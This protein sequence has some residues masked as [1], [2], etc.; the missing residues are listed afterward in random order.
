MPLSTPTI[1]EL[2]AHV[3]DQIAAGEVIEGPLSVVKELI[4]NSLDAGATHIR[5]DLKGGGYDEITVHDNGCGISADDMPRAL[6]K[7]AT[8]KLTT[9]DLW[10]ITS[11][12][13]RGEALAVIRSI[14][15]LSLESRTKDSP[16]G[17]L[18]A[19][20]VPEIQPIKRT[21][22]TT[23]YVRDLFY[24]TPARLKFAKSDRAERLALKQLL[25]RYGLC[26]PNVGFRATIDDRPFFEQ[27]AFPQYALED[28]LRERLR[29]L[30]PHAS[31]PGL[32][33]SAQDGDYHVRGMIASPLDHHHTRQHQYF[34]IQNRP[35]QDKVLATALALAY[36]DVIP[37]GRFP[38]SVVMLDVPPAKIDVNVHPT[39]QEVR[40]AEPKFLQSWLLKT[41]KSQL[42]GPLGQSFGRLKT[43]DTPQAQSILA[44]TSPS[45]PFHY[46]RPAFKPNQVMEDVVNLSPPYDGKTST[47]KTRDVPSQ[48]S[49]AHHTPPE[50][51]LPIENPPLGRV[52][53]QI[54]ASYIVTESKEG[55]VIID[56]HAAAER[57][58]YEKLKKD[59]T[60]TAP[61]ALLVPEHITLPE[62]SLDALKPAF[63][64]LKT[65]GLHL[66]CQSAKSV[67]AYSVPALLEGTRVTPLIRDLGEALS[68]PAAENSETHMEDHLWNTFCHVLGE[69]ACKNSI[70]ANHKLSTDEMEHLLRAME[71]TSL[72]GQCNHGRPTSV[73]LTPADLARL[74]KRA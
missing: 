63:E 71:K 66:E 74:F 37:H 28:S 6:L 31:S 52:L 22:G 54:H 12:G 21:T 44:N 3:V 20:N 2:P 19:D 72:S 1:I 70:K 64:K 30:L 73:L 61:H 25:V 38:W 23:V 45:K 24:N 15:R 7:H 47:V 69:R 4:E 29:N 59:L 48:S 18:L 27:D 60:H 9:G 10:N 56:Q 17:S 58:A 5:I 42:H 40:F 8:S 13:F 62:T 26:C 50:E 68:Q 49:F 14:S 41:L 11:L 51:T 43:N 34:F 16:L 39:K 53:G 46:N 35:V 33:V 65:W 57:L 32:F 55:L 36:Q 67:V